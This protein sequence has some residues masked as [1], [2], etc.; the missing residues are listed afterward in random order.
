LEKPNYDRQQTA[1]AVEKVG[2]AAVIKFSEFFCAWAAQLI[3]TMSASETLQDGFSCVEYHP[4][5]I[6]RKEIGLERK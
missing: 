1:N 4:P 3:G 2:F 6:Q 5:R